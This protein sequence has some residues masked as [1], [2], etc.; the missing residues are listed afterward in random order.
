MEECHVHLGGADFVE[1]DKDGGVEEAAEGQ[2]CVEGQ[3]DQKQQQG[4][5]QEGSQ[6]QGQAPGAVCS[7]V[8]HVEVRGE[9]VADVPPRQVVQV[10]FVEEVPAVPDYGSYG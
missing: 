10:G 5:G 2:V 1:G 9:V 6:T 7:Q 8:Q 3:G 4:L